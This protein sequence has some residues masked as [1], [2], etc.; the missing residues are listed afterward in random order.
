M[1]L[2]PRILGATLVAVVLATGACAGDDDGVDAPE[3]AKADLIEQGDALCQQGLDELS[4]SAE[5]ATGSESALIGQVLLPSIKETFEKVE[6]L[7][8]P[9]DDKKELRDI[10]DQLDDLFAAIDDPQQSVNVA[11]EFGKIAT[12]LKAYG[13]KVCGQPIS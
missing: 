1:R 10:Y 11:E 9:P 12:D 6:A 7:G 3:I 8:Y 4:E 2:R 5:N 13:F